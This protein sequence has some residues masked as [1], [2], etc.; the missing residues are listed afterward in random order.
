MQKMA[1]CVIPIKLED[2]Q[3]T[4]SMD[5]DLD[6]CEDEEIPPPPE[7]GKWEQPKGKMKAKGVKFAQEYHGNSC[8][9][10]CGCESSNGV[11]SVPYY[12]PLRSGF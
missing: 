10:G 1:G 9:Q 7:V 2:N 6:A 12:A 4:V 3:F 8:K 5:V 11:G